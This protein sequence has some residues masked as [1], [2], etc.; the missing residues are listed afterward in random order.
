MTRL[1][2]P[3][4]P[5]KK[6]LYAAIGV[7]LLLS[8]GTVGWYTLK[9]VF[10]AGPAGWNAGRIIDDAVFTNTTT[11]SVSEIQGFLQS[12]VPTCDTQG[13]QPS[14]FG[15]GT[16]AQWGSAHGN[17][18]PYTCLRDYTENGKKASQIIYNVA[19]QFKINPQVL[20]VVLQKEQSLV[21]DTWPLK[22][23]YKT[24][25]GYG[26]P[27]NA[28]CDSDYYGFTN[29][30]TWT[31]RM[32][33]AILNDSP[34][35]YTPYVLGNNY[36][37]YNPDSSCGGSTVN[38]QNRATKALY[39][40][41]PYQPNKG[42]LNAGWGTA[43]C[44][45]YGNRNF[46]LYFTQWFGSTKEQFV[47]LA[48]PR[49]MQIK[50]DT[51]KMDLWT[52]QDS[53]GTLAADRQLQFADKIYLDGNWY[54]RTASDK[55]NNVHKGVLLTDLEDIPYTNL[56]TPRWMNITHDIHKRNP[57][58][59]YGVDGTLKKD[60]RLFFSSQTVINGITF[61]RTKADTDDG[62]NKGVPSTALQEVPYVNFTKPRWMQLKTNATKIDPRTGVNTATN[63]TAGHQEKFTSKI[64]VND[65]WYYR[66][67]SDTTGDVS[68]GV[69]SSAIEDIPYVALSGGARTMQLKNN[70][71]KVNPRMG[72]TVQSLA[73]N[74]HIAFGQQITVNGILYYR[75]AADIGFGADRA[76]PASDV[77]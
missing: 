46:Y 30:V 17:P 28:A 41:T 44:G 61:Y 37:Q 38:I 59:G 35:W 64:Y 72:Y 68:A 18:P 39:N 66:N 49:W 74:R 23:Q 67:E 14:E 11:M 21:T 22:T 16:R 54:L 6:P 27:D 45:S 70:T 3:K 51:Y 52:G 2:L 63:W 73:K 19:Q 50:A 75:T 34:T 15:G 62:K 8:I 32:Y 57:A 5:S 29:Q 13:T 71:N 33:R 7:V 4:S 47:S 1:S 9:S 36:I 76:I 56:T 31:G 10:A 43:S 26:C 58:G 65:Q 25:T 60:R 48:R 12:K 69:P 55:A 40:Y 77:Q 53:G 24:A 20:L 42:A